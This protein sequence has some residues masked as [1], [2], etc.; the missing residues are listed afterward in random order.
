MID[1]PFFTEGRD[2]Q[3]I[4]LWC[5][6]KAAPLKSFL[7]SGTDCICSHK[8]VAFNNCGFEYLSVKGLSESDSFNNKTVSLGS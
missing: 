8:E 1:Y 5:I 6:H 4:E 2:S 3:D 7:F